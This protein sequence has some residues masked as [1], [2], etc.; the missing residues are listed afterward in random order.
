MTVVGGL[1]AV[2][3]PFLPGGATRADGVALAGYAGGVVL[4]VLLGLARSR[5]VR[6][7]GGVVGVLAAGAAVVRLV[8]DVTGGVPGA[9]T[10]VLAVGALGVAVGLLGSTSWRPRPVGVLAAVAVLAAAV[11]SPVVVDRAATRAE[12]RD[13]RDFAPEPVPARPGGRQWSWQ[14]PADVTDVAAA[15]HGV[16]VATADGA[17]TALDGPDG[18]RQWAYARPGAHVRDVLV[19]T[20]GEAV[21]VA[22][23][24]A[25]DTRSNLLVVL[26]ADTGAERFRRVVPA[27]LVQTRQVVVTTRTL[28][29]RDDAYTAYDLGTGEERWRWSPP[30]GCTS[31]FSLLARGRTA[32]LAPVQ[33]PGEVGLLALDEVTGGERWRHEVAVDDSAGERIDVLPTS[34]SDG[35]AVWLRIVGGPAA[36]GSVTSGMF[37]TGTGALLAGPHAPWWPRADVGVTPLLEQQEGAE[38]E[39]LSALDPTGASHPLDL[40]LCPLR[41]ADATTAST[42]LRLCGDTG[43]DVTLVVQAWDGS[44]PTSVPVRLDG[45][46]SRQDL[47]LVPAPGA[48]VVARGTSGG[49]PAPVV[50]L[51][52]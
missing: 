11:A 27:V 3:A 24:S 25:G 22:F 21:A 14:P 34:T 16:V 30:D 49:T 35:A 45:S 51:S 12:T 28:A 7:A 47:H 38:V 19:S 13:A 18:R 20:D 8:L 42:Y 10:A 17:V 37:D 40:A 31:P 23:G 33:C 1:C 46:G 15:G 41:S 50:G 6:V 9:D 39:A 32:V 43:R 52:G 5:R 26:D 4:A 48:I 44:P 29:I 2:A 36:P